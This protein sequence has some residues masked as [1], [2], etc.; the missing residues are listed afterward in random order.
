[1]SVL[2]CARGTKGQSQVPSH[3]SDPNLAIRD[4]LSP[5]YKSKTKDQKNIQHSKP[6]RNAKI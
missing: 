3:S 1:M 4:F 2:T 5:S 6:A